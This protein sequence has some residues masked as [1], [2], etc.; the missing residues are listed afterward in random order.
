[1]NIKPDKGRKGK[2]GLAASPSRGLGSLFLARL[3]E[4]RLSQK[5]PAKRATNTEH[6]RDA[7]TQENRLKK[8]YASPNG[9]RT[10]P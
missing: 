5:E 6:D 2:N 4:S 3:E 1:L 10:T 8:K 9:P 7:S